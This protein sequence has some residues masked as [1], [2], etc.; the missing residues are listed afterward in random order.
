MSHNYENFLLIKPSIAFWVLVNS[1]GVA[2]SCE[3]DMRSLSP[4]LF[5]NRLGG[6]LVGSVE[7]AARR[8]EVSARGEGESGSH[9][10][11]CR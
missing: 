2:E 7:G 1:L 10:E 11:S 6:V 5:R 8:R 4:A 9:I 3:L